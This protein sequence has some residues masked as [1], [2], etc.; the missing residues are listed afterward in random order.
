M[1][2][3]GL[4]FEKGAAFWGRRQRGLLQP[5]D[6]EQERAM[7]ETAID[8]LTAAG[9]EHYEVSNFARPGHRCRHNQVYWRGQ[10]ISPSVP[11]PPAM[12]TAGER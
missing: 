8:V 11:A 4:T 6:E 3:Y 5:V 1:S 9:L 2:T 7:Y 10:S 12:W